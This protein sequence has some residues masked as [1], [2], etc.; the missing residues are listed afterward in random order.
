MSAISAPVAASAEPTGQ[1]EDSLSAD[2][3]V[4]EAF[5]LVDTV[6]PAVTS[7]PAIALSATVSFAKAP[8]TMLLSSSS[9]ESLEVEA[10]AE[11]FIEFAAL[12]TSPTQSNDFS[13]L[14]APLHQSLNIETPLHSAAALPQAEDRGSDNFQLVRVISHALDENHAATLYVNDI[15]VLTFI[16]QEL[17]SLAA[18]SV[19][20]ADMTPDSNYN[21]LIA[22]DPAER[23]SLAARQ[24][25]QFHTSEGDPET[26]LV[27]WD[28][29][30]EEYAIDI[31]D[32]TLV[33]INE[34][35]ILPDTTSDFAEDALQATNRLR[36][37][38]GGAEPLT[39]IEGQPEVADQPVIVAAG[40]ESWDVTSVFTGQASWYGPGFHGRRTASGE[41]FNQEALTAAHRTLPFGTRVLVTN[42]NNDSQVIVRINDRGPFIHG[43]IL[44]LSAA[45]A[46]EIGLHGAGVGQIRLEV[47]P[48]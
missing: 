16:G 11:P 39:A 36:R 22:I 3:D 6:E 30:L 26:I 2:E 32:E 21:D 18:K 23:A 40:S 41:V 28:T 19:Q 44:D 45:A 1:M 7:E 12:E 46:R 15:P 29:D 14:E 33:L 9:G 20:E 43:R 8:K 38:L 10:S 4:G 47:L 24:L 17:E 37:L 25:E 27:R 42:L 48:D 31:A 34:A 35:A 13:E 5:E